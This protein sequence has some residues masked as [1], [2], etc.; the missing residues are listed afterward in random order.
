MPEA[1][2]YEIPPDG[3]LQV[4]DWF[5]NDEMI[6]T[7]EYNAPVS[8]DRE[9]IERLERILVYGGPALAQYTLL[10][11]IRM[12][13]MM[14]SYWCVEVGAAAR[15]APF[16]RKHS[17][18]EPPFDASGMTDRKV[19]GYENLKES[20]QGIL[21][22]GREFM[23]RNGFSPENASCLHLQSEYK[24]YY[25]T[26]TL[27]AAMVLIRRMDSVKLY[28]TLD[29]L[30]EKYVIA[31]EDAIGSIYPLLWDAYNHVIRDGRH[32]TGRQW[33]VLRQCINTQKLSAEMHAVGLTKYERETLERMLQHA[34]G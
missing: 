23:E 32:F 12:P 13:V 10:L 21:E 34:Q 24:V 27:E 29:P 2:V 7:S 15:A 18:Y 9:I 6:A 11:H 16:E 19:L 1:R 3:Y 20:I 31:L 26:I 25:Q 8:N 22:Q 30:M 28:A 17:H 5:G 14:H 4:A 33:D